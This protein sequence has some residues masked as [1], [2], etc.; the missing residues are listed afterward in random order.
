[1]VGARAACSAHPSG[2][3]WKASFV[4]HREGVDSAV[5]LS[6]DNSVYEPTLLSIQS[7]S[8]WNDLV[9]VLAACSAHPSGVRCKPSFVLH[10]EE[11]DGA[12]SLSAG[13]PVYEP[14]ILSMKSKSTK[15]TWNDLVGVGGA[16]CSAHPSGVRWTPSLVLRG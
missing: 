1:M 16:A 4:L 6:A 9:G 8:T 5:S 15:S 3:R 2:V 11:L 7:K 13:N 14:T 12:A 10:R